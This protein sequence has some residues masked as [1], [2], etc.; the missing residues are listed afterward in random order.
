MSPPEWVVATSP[1]CTYIT[2]STYGSKSIDMRCRQAAEFAAILWSEG[3]FRHLSPWRARAFRILPIFLP[4]E[5][6]SHR[7][8]NGMSRS[9]PD[10]RRGFRRQVASCAG[11]Q[12][13]SKPSEHQRRHFATSGNGREAVPL[14]AR[15]SMMDANPDLRFVNVLGQFWAQH[16]TFQR[17]SSVGSGV[18]ANLNQ[19]WHSFSLAPGTSA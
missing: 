14:A 3:L 15:L 10:P 12:P 19:L 9:R 18:L 8:A 7:K 4:Y 5:E 13:I 17:C 6:F 16:F 1:T 2:C 11:S